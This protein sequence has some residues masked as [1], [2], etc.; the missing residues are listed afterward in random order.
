MWELES[1]PVGWVTHLV[2]G[3]VTQ[4]VG[5]VKQPELIVSWITF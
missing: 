2:V 3:W 1:Q 5:L 4:L